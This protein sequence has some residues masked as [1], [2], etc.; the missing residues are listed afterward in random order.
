MPKEAQPKILLHVCCATC[1]PYVLKILS[2]E[3]EPTVYFYNPNIHPREEYQ[4][5]LLD[6]EGYVMSLG[7]SFI[8]AV[9]DEERWHYMVSGLEHDHEGGKRCVICFQMRLN[10]VALYAA[11]N[12]FKW[13]ATTLTVS[14]HKN[15]KV[16]NRICRELAQDYGLNFY[17][18]D[19]KKQDGAKISFKMARD[20]DFYHQDY[21]G[22][23]H[24]L[25]ETRERHRLRDE[26]ARQSRQMGSP[27]NTR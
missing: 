26:S 9:Y 14:P 4:R 25:Y 2:K 24:S 20:L 5:R 19:F 7:Y 1:S 16:I 17:D 8:D 12:G 10:K 13:F 15:S 18:A 23:I 22:C 3:F 21:C 27:I 11:V 6:I